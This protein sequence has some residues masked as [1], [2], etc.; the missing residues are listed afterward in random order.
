M[1]SM[2]SGAR[3][4]VL[5]GA[6]LLYAG[7]MVPIGGSLPSGSAPV[8]EPHTNTNLTA[9]ARDLIAEVNRTRNA[10]G[11]AALSEDAALNRAAR[12]HSEELAARRT[13][14]HSST[15]PDRRTMTMRIEAAGGSWLQAAENLAGMSGPAS[16]IPTQAVQMWLGSDGHRR[17]MLSASYTHTGVGIAADR[18]GAWYITQLY[19]LPRPAR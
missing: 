15:N 8:P 13:L 3:L 11:V 10:Q 14:D 16:R 9:V 17:N 12:E 5:L 4:R 1:Q 19:V 7:C 6:T 2:M 18:Y